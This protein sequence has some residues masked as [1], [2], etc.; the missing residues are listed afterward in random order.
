MKGQRNPFA[1]ISKRN[2]TETIL[3]GTTISGKRNEIRR[4][5]TTFKAVAQTAS[6][7]GTKNPSMFSALLKFP[8]T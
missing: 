6:R 3:Y 5:K 8:V 4:I 7:N 2:E 1:R